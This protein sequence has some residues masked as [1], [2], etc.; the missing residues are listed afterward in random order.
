MKMKVAAGRGR[1]RMFA[2]TRCEGVRVC[3]GVYEGVCEGVCLCRGQRIDV[4]FK[5]VYFFEVQLWF[6]MCNLKQDEA[7]SASVQTTWQSEKITVLACSR[8]QEG[9]QQTADLRTSTGVIGHARDNTRGFRLLM[10]IAGGSTCC[11][12]QITQTV[13]YHSV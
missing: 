6:N 3:E 1:V 12:L 11:L 10:R 13:V 9:T 2:P 4:N 5:V 7:Y 8:L